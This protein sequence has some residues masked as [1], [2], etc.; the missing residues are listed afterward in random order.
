MTA[1]PCLVSPTPGILKISLSSFMMILIQWNIN[2]FF[3]NYNDL[4]L[5]VSKYN[6]D[7]ILLQETH[8]KFSDNPSLRGY[9]VVSNKSLFDSAHGG[10][11]I[12]LRNDMVFSEISLNPDI[13]AVAVSSSFNGRKISF[14]S[15]YLKPQL[16]SIQT[17][18]TSIYSALASPMIIGGDFNSHSVTWGCVRTNTKGNQLEDF[19]L[20]NQVSLLN[21]GS[22]TYLHPGHGSLSA[23]DIT[24]SSPALSISLE[25]EVVTEAYNSDHQPILVKD[26]FANRSNTHRVRWNED[27]ADWGIFFNSCVGAFDFPEDLE[28]TEQVRMFNEAIL[29]A[30]ALS[31]P[32]TREIPGKRRVPWWT[33][34]VKENVKERNRLFRKF[35]KH[36][37]GANLDLLNQ[38]KKEV[39]EVIKQA[40]A[41]SWSSYVS[42]IKT[43][44]PPKVVWDKIRKISGKHRSVVIRELIENG[45]VANTEEDMSEVLARTFAK[46][47]DDSDSSDEA[48]RQ[49]ESLLGYQTVPFD[50]TCV[51]LNL[52]FSLEEMS[53]ALRVAKGRS[54]GPDGITYQMLKN[55]PPQGKSRLLLILNKVFSEGTIPDVWKTANIIPILKPD[56]DPTDPKSYRPIS[57]LSCVGK[58]LEKMV[59][60]RL[61]WWLESNHLLSDYQSGFR[62]NRCTTD[63]L[64]YLQ[65]FMANK[66]N[67]KEHISCISLDI[68]KAYEKVWRIVIINK[69][70]DWGLEGRIFK[71]I[72]NFL[73]D[74]QF[75]VYVGNK[76]SSRFTQENGTPTGSVLSVPLFLIAIN[77]SSDYLNIPG[78]KHVLYA[79]DL[80]IFASAN[81][82]ENL[83]MKLQTAVDELEVWAQQYG[84][85]FSIPK[86]KTLHVC[87]RRNCRHPRF[88]LKNNRISE[89]NNLKILGILFDSRLSFQQ[90]I[91][92][93]KD[94][95][96]KRVN[97]IKVLSNLEW[98]ADRRQLLSVHQAL[99]GGKL[100]YGVVSF[101]TAA[102]SIL[103]KLD[104]IHNAGIR[105]ATGAFRS[106]PTDS[107]IAESGLMNLE[108]RRTLLT[109]KY[110]NKIS[111]N[112]HIIMYKEMCAG[113]RAGGRIISWVEKV[114]SI[115]AGWNL[116]RHNIF[117]YL[118]KQPYWTMDRSRLDISLDSQ[119]YRIDPNRSREVIYNKLEG[120]NLNTKIFVAG[121]KFS[122][123]A[124]YGIWVE[125][126]RWI[127]EGKV[128]DMAS[129][130]T[131]EEKALIAACKLAFNFPNPLIIT[132]CLQALKNVCNFRLLSGY[133]GQLRDLIVLGRF[134]FLYDPGFSEGIANANA[135]AFNAANHLISDF[136]IS[137][138]DC[139]SW[140]KSTVRELRK[141]RWKDIPLSNKLRYIKDIP[142]FKNHF[143]NRR[144]QVTLTR[145]RIGHCNFSHSF[146]MQREQQP[147]CQ[148]CNVVLT[149]S[150]VLV[151]CPSYAQERRRFN[152]ENLE[153]QQLLGPRF[154]ILE[155][156][157][158]FVAATGLRV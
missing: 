142:I 158:S 79:D 155:R 106:S 54:A 41:E 62:R 138:K 137:I 60:S 98:G 42:S 154:E 91:K 4:K 63:N 50:N 34:S 56:K 145:L 151:E 70:R 136:Q 134:N 150:H 35:R 89:V 131:L 143:R 27:R 109:V 39:K 17:E 67:E 112:Q 83:Q 77:S 31:M 78:V 114:S 74:R 48:L 110:W 128:N 149:V 81:S 132:N 124:G 84:F 5:L 99:V 13:D 53:Q 40:K 55:L 68:E 8:L 6:P 26:F 126:S 141:L 58:L 93:I 14:C 15:V 95:C 76:M 22:P 47:S 57:L 152:I 121:N 23:I 130:T 120:N 88:S 85:N 71:Y 135:S 24:L 157:V 37:S 10:S 51:E 116:P 21:D 3:N 65:N 87:R 36:P 107:L 2:G 11:A 52:P 123:K 100:D 140:A 115:L 9:Q 59:S 44:T 43:D 102:K 1:M 29:N 139:N 92:E 97:I 38:K 148:S 64:A 73:R 18:I 19:I 111:A 7:I 147:R 75:N 69:L 45:D 133:T 82:S 119:R 80:L 32:Q 122:G 90:H 49:R 86:S 127:V 72:D 156:T 104:P 12:L 20:N 101:C 16:R 153:I 33:D 103:K 118:G 28:L 129:K 46:N 25:W 30:A 94:N 125:N 96:Q 66:I 113:F 108:D 61:N 144:D 105:A 117:H 146:L